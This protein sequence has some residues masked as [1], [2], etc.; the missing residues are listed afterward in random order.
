MIIEC[1]YCEAKVD[2]E[3]LAQH[4]EFDP[5]EDPFP[6]RT[7]F[8]VCP[9]CKNSMLGGQEQIDGGWDLVSRLWPSP[10]QYLSLTIPTVV[11]TSIEEARKCF[12]AG[13]YTA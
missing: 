8:L 2:A 12:T 10:K 7:F 6:F 4:E 5:E 9:S 3:V 11:R 1:S 13:A